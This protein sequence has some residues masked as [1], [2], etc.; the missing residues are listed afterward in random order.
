MYIYSY[1]FTQIENNKCDAA[2]VVVAIA[3]ASLSPKSFV[4]ESHDNL[5]SQTNIF[6]KPCHV[7]HLTTHV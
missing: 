7:L 4:L 6:I 1:S 3:L 5:K 2:V